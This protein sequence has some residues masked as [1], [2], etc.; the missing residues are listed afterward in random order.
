MTLTEP[1][2]VAC[3][4]GKTHLEDYRVGESFESNARTMTESDLVLYSMFSG[5]WE[6]RAA[7]DGRLLVPEMFALSV[8]LCLLLGAGRYSWMP[9]SF[10]AFYGFDEIHLS[11]GLCVGD[12][13]SSTVRVVDLHERDAQRGIVDY[14]HETTDQS[15]RL[16]CSSSHRILVGRRPP[17]GGA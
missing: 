4:D 15:Q 7:A 12:T 17:G 16:V 9:K 13:I 5:D 2:T 8:G 3:G 1:E 14:R 6:R 10:I 11:G